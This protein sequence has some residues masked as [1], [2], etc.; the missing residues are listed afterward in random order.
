MMLLCWKCSGIGVKQR[1]AQERSD[2]TEISY[3]VFSATPGPNFYLPTIKLHDRAYYFLSGNLWLAHSSRERFDAKRACGVNKFRTT[4]NTHRERNRRRAFSVRFFFLRRN[5]GW[6][7]FYKNIRPT[8]PVTLYG[9]FTQER[10]RLNLSFIIFEVFVNL[11]FKVV[12]I[13]SI[14]IIPVTEDNLKPFPLQIYKLPNEHSHKKNI[15]S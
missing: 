9:P 7:D 13:L 10:V 5:S 4:R 11:H 3:H 8:V 6:M 12:H 1:A 15:F 2:A 14:F